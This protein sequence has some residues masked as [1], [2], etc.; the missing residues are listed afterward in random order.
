MNIYDLLNKLNIPFQEVEHPAVYTVNDAEQLQIDLPGMEVK[1]LFLGDRKDK[2]K[3]Y[4]YCL[5]A[6]KRA[7]LKGLRN[8]IGSGALTFASEGDLYE[9]MSLTHGSVTPLG[10]IND[11]DHNVVLLIDRELEGKTVWVHPN[12][13]TKTMSITMDDILRIAKNLGTQVIFV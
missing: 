12:V 10:L 7:D 8:E 13:N 2:R 9:K 4:L 11:Q 1:N 3:Y 6:Y 5:P